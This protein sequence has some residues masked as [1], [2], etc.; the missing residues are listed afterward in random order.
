MSQTNLCFYGSHQD[1][2]YLHSLKSSVGGYT[3]FLKLGKV[4]TLAEVSIYCASKNI[5]GIIST[6]IPFLSKLLNWD[7]RKAPSLA[8]YAGSLFIIPGSNVEVVFVHPLKQTITKSYGRFLLKR[9]CDKLVKKDKWFPKIPFTWNIMYPET[10]EEDF[11]YLSQSFLIAV[12]IE[13]FKDNARIRCVSFCGFW[14]D[15]KTGDIASHASVLPIDSE[16][17][18]AL[19]KKLCWELKAP[20]VLQNGKYD[21][22]YLLRYNAPLYNYVYDTAN[23][24]HSWYAELPKSL[25]ALNAFFVRDAMYWKDLAETNDL[26]EYYRYNAL[27][28]WAT[29]V[30]LIATVLESPQWAKDNY[31]LEFPTVFPCIL[32]EM[33]GV[34]R[35]Q[36]RLESTKEEQQAKDDKVVESL[37]NILSEPNFNPGSPKQ[38]I[39]LLKLLGCKDI[40]SSDEKSITK[41]MFRHPFNRR[42]LGLI[43]NSRKARKLLTTYLTTGEKA[44]EFH[45]PNGSGN[46][47]LWAL[48]PHGTETSRLAS[49]EHH[50][51]CGLQVQNQPR[52]KLVK[53]TYVADPGFYL[54]EVD[55]EQAESRDTAY[56]SG[57]EKLI[58]A[59]E[60]SR[61]F[62]SVNCE[63]F[64]GVAYDKIYDDVN[65]VVI[66]KK[67]RDIAKRVNHGAN[68]NMGAYILI[69]TMGEE[70]I[71]IAR[72]LLGLPKVWSLKEVAEYLL[73]GFH[74]TYPKIRGTMYK[75]V[76]AEIAET[77]LL[78]SKAYHH[79][80][81][82]HP[83]SYMNDEVYEQLIKENPPWTRYCFGDPTKSKMILNS[84]IAHPPQSLNAQTL[85]KAWIE[86]FY[87]IAIH[88]K[89]SK[90]FK[91]CAQIHDSIL[92]QYRIGHDYL[93]DMVKDMMEIPIT[94]KGYDNKIRRFTVPA[95]IKKGLIS[96]ATRELVPAKY[97]SETE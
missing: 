88:P 69:E 95:G 16:Y 67:L 44:K 85:N 23:M 83:N 73:E 5:S 79:S 68:Y 90:N 45:R 34:A 82:K 15:P 89:H 92:F 59:V 4:T 50:F 78:R 31:L 71:L 53:Q 6:S 81:D 39:Q 91:L 80:Y 49:K 1:K 72:N 48:N 62:H 42:V 27:D 60:S 52:G 28:T 12:D 77:K 43:A 40:T 14:A 11:L 8:N 38:V 94:V 21:I 54:A 75:G 26:H 47:I 37:R 96:Q 87:K 29:G 46:R 10:F 20:K 64:F 13:T 2:E 86:V 70:K 57:E 76:I 9:Y 35:D 56:I 65:K 63:A 97:W 33:T 36:D 61:D 84:Y 30:C 7:K 93:C 24:F 17:N 25:G 66:D 41:A 22:N 32:A 19:L 18:L 58:E 74:K 55:L 3:C 51:W